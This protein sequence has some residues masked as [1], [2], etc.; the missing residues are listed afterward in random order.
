MERKIVVPESMVMQIF[1]DFVAVF[2][3]L[4]N[5]IS[6]YEKESD[7]KKRHQAYLH[8]REMADDMCKIYSCIM[9]GMEEHWRSVFALLLGET[10]KKEAV[11]RE[12]CEIQKPD[13]SVTIGI[14]EYEDMVDDALCLAECIDVLAVTIKELLELFPVS[15]ELKKNCTSICD[16]ARN[17]ADSVVDDW[18]ER[19]A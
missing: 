9:V 14:E 3:M 13:N 17:L 5:L 18:Q 2:G 6:V 4:N 1:E 7:L 15:E 10:E 19:E 11:Q 8:V 12:E 16:D